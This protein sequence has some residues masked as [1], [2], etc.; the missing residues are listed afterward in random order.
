MKYGT[1]A[2]AKHERS[3][4]GDACTVQ[5]DGNKILLALVDGLGSGEEAA[6][7][8]QIAIATIE[9]DQALPLTEIL[10]HC[11]RALRTTRGVVLGMLRVDLEAQEM[12]YVGVGNVGIRVLSQESFHPISYN[13]IVGYRLP[14][15]HEFVGQYHPG[16]LI[17][18]YSDGIDN[19]FHG[20]EALLYGEQDLEALATAIATRYGKEDDICVLVAR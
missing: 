6:K 20:D 1:Y 11:H 3:V 13:G 19:R 7:A 16:D 18:L 9:E 17:V 10:K 12:R 2:R 5:K 8:A 15:T 4:S 14:R